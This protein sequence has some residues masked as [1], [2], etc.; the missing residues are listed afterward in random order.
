M[1][2]F[3]VSNYGKRTGIFKTTKELILQ[4]IKRRPD[5]LNDFIYSNE[6]NIFLESHQLIIKGEIVI[7]FKSNIIIK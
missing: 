1:D 2:Y 5:R 6:K 4:S 7:P 3:I